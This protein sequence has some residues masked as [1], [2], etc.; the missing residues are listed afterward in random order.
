MCA[1]T[2]KE[3]S[4]FVISVVSRLTGLHTQTLR[5]YE[6]AGIVAPSRSK[7][8]IR[9]YSLNDIERIKQVK[10][11]I[12]DL[13]LNLAGVE[14]ILGMV[15]RM[16]EMQRKIADLEAEVNRDRHGLRESEG[17]ET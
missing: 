6:R 3:G 11:L 14:V 15:E 10:S 17:T 8:N 7:G 4:F 5:Y 12:D 16:K 1:F 2:S 13:G 9:L